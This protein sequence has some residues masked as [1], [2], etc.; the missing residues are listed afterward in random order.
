MKIHAVD[1]YIP[2][3]FKVSYPRYVELI[4]EYSTFLNLHGSTSKLVEYVD[5]VKKDFGIDNPYYSRNDV[6]FKLGVDSEDTHMCQ[7]AKYLNES[8]GTVESIK[9]YF[10]LAFGSKVK[11]VTPQNTIMR[12]SVT[13]QSTTNTYL[14]EI[15]DDKV[16]TIKN[17]SGISPYIENQY[18]IPTT[19]KAH[20]IMCDAKT[21]FL[22]NEI[23]NV[24]NK[25]TFV[26]LP[27]VPDFSRCF[28]FL[29]GD[30]V[31]VSD[32]YT[33]GEYRV[34]S[35]RQ[36]G[37]D[38]VTI[39]DGGTG[40][41]VG[42][43]VRSRIVSGFFATVSSVDNNGSIVTVNV[44]NRGKFEKLSE[45]DVISNTGTGALVEIGQNNIG[46]INTFD[47]IQPNIDSTPVAIST[48]NKDAVVDITALVQQQVITRKLLSNNSV[49][50]VNNFV[51]DS[52]KRHDNSYTIITKIPDY[53]WKSAVDTH[54]NKYGNN[55]T[56]LYNV[57]EQSS[58]Y[59]YTNIEIE[60]MIT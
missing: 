9:C 32:A 21:V 40:Y 2:S 51:I 13:W 53:L 7:V 17:S 6:F 20:V 49:T 44:K 28:N 14:I 5:Y 46:V 4:K 19:P 55:Y 30:Y 58:T 27:F 37:I 45:I 15:D 48:S 3:T 54:L 11:I 23:V 47:V 25:N 31:T 8:A 52:K 26:K 33:I 36:G 34:A 35:V 12:A 22:N 39:T 59:E 60:V 56:V 16:S 50:G 1:R 18:S 41:T 29:V 43:S 57:V 24:N 38:T 42:D 10:L